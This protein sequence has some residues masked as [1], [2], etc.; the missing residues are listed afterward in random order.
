LKG[1]PR[2]QGRFLMERQTDSVL[3]LT[4]I[5]IKPEVIQVNW[6]WNGGYDGNQ[7]LYKDMGTGGYWLKQDNPNGGQN[8]DYVQVGANKTIKCYVRTY[9]N[10]NGVKVYSPYSGPVT[11]TTNS[12]LYSPAISV[13]YFTDRKAVIDIRDSS[14]SNTG[15]TLER[16]IGSSGSFTLLTTINDSTMYQ[17]TDSGALISGQTYYYRMRAFSGSTYSTYSDTVS[18][19]TYTNIA[20]NKTAT[21]SSTT[22]PY[23]APKAVDGDSTSDASRWAAATTIPPTAWWKVDLGAVDSVNGFGIVWRIAGTWKYIIYGSVDDSNWDNIRDSSWT[24]PTTQTHY[25]N[26]G[27]TPL[28]RYIKILVTKA[29]S[30]VKPGFYEF[31]VFGRQ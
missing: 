24:T 31:R 12:A 21:A 18:L 15:F 13:N 25:I 7:I 4:S 26:L 30:G 23:T 29:P 8:S 28:Y 22:S 17:Y 27:W 19:T 3:N 2:F 16:K 11:V 20:L 9:R 6:W 1:S 10:Y 14:V 5:Q